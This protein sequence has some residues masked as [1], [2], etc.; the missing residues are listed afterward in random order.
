MTSCLIHSENA[1]KGPCHIQPYSPDQLAFSGLSVPVWAK[2][3][4]YQH[5]QYHFQFWH[6]TQFTVLWNSFCEWIDWGSLYIMGWL[7]ET[8]LEIWITVATSVW[9]H[10]YCLVSL[11]VQQTSIN[12]D[13]CSFFHMES[14]NDT[15]F[16]CMYLHFRL[17]FSQTAVYL[18]LRTRGKLWVI[19]GKVLL[20]YRHHMPWML[21][22]N[23]I[24]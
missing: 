3:V 24:K 10:I 15:S 17:S 5:S 2:S 20:L 14:F 11:N 13:M 18:S 12:G 4:V 9:I 6:L 22:A 16:F 23:T 1:I 21:W 8:W 19:S 7:P